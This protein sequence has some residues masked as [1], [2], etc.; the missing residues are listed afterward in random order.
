MENSL[1]EN[2]EYRIGDYKVQYV[3]WFD[4]EWAG[5]G[6][7]LSATITNQRLLVFPEFGGQERPT[8]VIPSTAIRRVWNVC[9]RGRDGVMVALKDGRRLYMLVDWSQGSKLVRDMQDMLTPPTKPR[10]RPRILPQH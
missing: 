6:Y 8:E 7:W 10:I 4:D 1:L 5:T 3:R 2:D 9:L